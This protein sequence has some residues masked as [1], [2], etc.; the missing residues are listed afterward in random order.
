MDFSR[1]SSQTAEP[2]IAEPTIVDGW[3]GGARRILSP[4]YNPRP[5]TGI[6]LLVIHNISLPPGEFGGTYVDDFFSNCL[7]PSGHSYFTEIC[8]LQVSAHLLID[9]AGEVTQYV[10][11]ND[12]AWHAGQSS[13]CGRQNCNDFS[14]GIELEGCDEKPFSDRQYSS[15]IE[16]TRVIRAAFPAITPERIVGH[17]DI[18]PGRKTDPGPCFEW[19]RYRRAIA[20]GAS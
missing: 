12:R 13:F 9:R 20:V 8:H 14:I 2:T 3:L 4:N 7:D 5:A 17:S 19:D 1:Q 6:D 10:S 16:V 15:L 11:F 18:A